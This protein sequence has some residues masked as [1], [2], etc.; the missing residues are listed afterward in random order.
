MVLAA[1]IPLDVGIDDACDRVRAW[2]R[3]EIDRRLRET[4]TPDPVELKCDCGEPVAVSV[5][6]ATT[7]RS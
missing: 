1:D 5:R 6:Y 4:V 2:L 3:S 7:R